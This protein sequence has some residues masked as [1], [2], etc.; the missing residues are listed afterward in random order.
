[1]LIISLMS[2]YKMGVVINFFILDYQARSIIYFYNF[3]LNRLT[4]ND[5]IGKR[6]IFKKW[7]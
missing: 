1:M 5:K 2:G 6:I 7:A 3:G 4:D